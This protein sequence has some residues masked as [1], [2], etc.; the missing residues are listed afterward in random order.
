VLL[1]LKVER[2]KEITIISTKVN[3]AQVYCPE[4]DRERERERE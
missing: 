3:G 4:K 1:E 2:K